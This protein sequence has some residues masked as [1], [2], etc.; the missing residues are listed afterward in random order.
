MRLDL[1][2]HHEASGKEKARAGRTIEQQQNSASKQ[3]T[4]CEQAKNCGDEPSP[5]T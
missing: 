4:E 3:H 2:V 5:S 1:V